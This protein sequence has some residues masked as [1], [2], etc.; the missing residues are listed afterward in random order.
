MCSHAIV[1]HAAFRFC[2]LSPVM[3]I[4]QLDK[5]ARSALQTGS[6]NVGEGSVDTNS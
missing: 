1:A 3:P 5:N 2:M 6:A 4:A